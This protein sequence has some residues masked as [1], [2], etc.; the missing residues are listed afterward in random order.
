MRG[1]W[2]GLVLLENGIVEPG[3]VIATGIY[4][5]DKTTSDMRLPSS[6]AEGEYS[7]RVGSI[8]N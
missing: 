4:G 1:V 7:P 6:A 5:S 2:V 3:E 8:N